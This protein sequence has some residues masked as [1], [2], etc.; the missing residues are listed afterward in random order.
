MKV[1][2]VLNELNPSGAEVMLLSAA[3]YFINKKI[4][5]E[6]LV[7]G[8][9]LGIF[10]E[11]LNLVGYFIHHI[12]FE[13]KLI[14][15]FRAY[16]LFSMEYDVIHLHV[17]RG[18]FWLGLMARFAG[19]QVVIRTVHN[20][21]NFIGN[22]R[23]RRSLQRKTLSIFGVKHIAISESVQK[24]ELKRF[25]IPTKLISNWYDS[26]KFKKRTQNERLI[27][28]EKLQ[29]EEK[30]NVIV[31][32]GNCSN[33]K[34]HIAIIEAL[35]IISV[36][37][38]PLYLHVGMEDHEHSERKLV[39]ALGLGDSV[40]FI[41]PLEDVRSVLHAADLFLMPSLYEGF[42]IAATEA[43]AVGLPALLTSVSG[44]VDFKNITS[45]AIYSE[46]D[47]KSI[48]TAITEF[49]MR[50]NFELLEMQ[51]NAAIAMESHFNIKKGVDLY[52][53]VYR[54]EKY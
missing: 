33:V 37:K 43:M 26:D 11:K 2:H 21:F 13:K 9:S 35:M 19:V 49:F 52:C 3:P 29:I 30:T 34:N 42:G 25:G 41:G 28:R 27:A 40:R 45:G 23:L 7:T 36:N 24:N 53:E 38:R 20:N 31:S 15:F 6:I 4:K 22:L 8:T 1:L 51:C 47:P 46:I 50:D 12:P 39:T 17:E 14:F 10:S 5:S 32:I 44:L 54:Q 16:K 18:N 48:A